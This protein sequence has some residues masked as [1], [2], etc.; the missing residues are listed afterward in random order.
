[1]VENLRF[2]TIAPSSL[3]L[4]HCTFL[5]APSS[6]HLPHCIRAM[7]AIV[8]AT[9]TSIFQIKGCKDKQAIFDIIMFSFYE[10]RRVFILFGLI[11]WHLNRS[12]VA[13]SDATS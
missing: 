6:L 11:F 9:I 1:M 7:P 2:S 13:Q 8:F 10:F 4:P 5:I 12:F 3:H